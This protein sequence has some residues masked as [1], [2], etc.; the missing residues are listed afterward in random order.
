LPLKLSTHA[1]CACAHSPPLHFARRQTLF[2]PATPCFWPHHQV[3]LPGHEP[4]KELEVHALL[5]TAGFHG[6]NK[7]QENEMNRHVL[8]WRGV[9]WSRGRRA[10]VKRSIQ[11]AAA[12]VPAEPP[13]CNCLLHVSC[14]QVQHSF[15]ARGGVATPAVGTQHHRPQPMTPCEQCWQ[16]LQRLAGRRPGALLHYALS[17]RCLPPP[18]LPLCVRCL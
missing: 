11:H 5:N 17:F 1:T 15:C 8:G 6:L 7:T 9:G 2:A 4:E 18:C 16:R 14:Q 12:A 10:V 3:E 13:P